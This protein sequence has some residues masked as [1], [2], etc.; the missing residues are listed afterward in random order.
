MAKQKKMITRDD[1]SEKSKSDRSNISN[2][3]NKPIRNLTSNVYISAVKELEPYKFYCDI[4]LKPKKLKN[5]IV[6]SIDHCI[7]LRLIHYYGP[8]QIGNQVKKT[9]YILVARCVHDQHRNVI[10]SVE[11]D[12]FPL[13]ITTDHINRT[14]TLKNFITQTCPQQILFNLGL[15]FFST[16][17]KF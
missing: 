11:L 1:L 7:H 14:F 12:G 17:F 4:G 8:C 3:T 9:V 10:I 15:I 6:E 2:Q 16:N 13:K 5:F